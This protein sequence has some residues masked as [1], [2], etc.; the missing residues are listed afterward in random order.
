MQGIRNLIRYVE[1][2]PWIRKGLYSLI[3]FIFL[4]RFGFLKTLLLW[5][6]GK[7]FLRRVGAI[8]R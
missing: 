2:R 1:R 6:E 4:R 3:G 7:D 8:V 5:K